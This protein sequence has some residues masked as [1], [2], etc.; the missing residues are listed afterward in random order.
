MV[1]E[2]GLWRASPVFHDNR[3]TCENELNVKTSEFHTRGRLTE[4]RDKPLLIKIA[5]LS[6]VVRAAA[7]SERSI[8][9]EWKLSSYQQEQDPAT[10]H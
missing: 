3:P 1:V 8:L 9:F 2:V 10:A 4:E 7:A 5:S 6:T